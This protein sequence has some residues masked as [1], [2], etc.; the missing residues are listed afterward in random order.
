MNF[1]YSYFISH[2][3][4]T[5]QA[6]QMANIVEEW[7]DQAHSQCKDEEARCISVVKTLVVAKK[8][9]KELKTKPTEV[10]REGKSAE[11][12]LV[13]TQETSRGPMSTV[14]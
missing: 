6:I 13:G 7:V 5:F 14:A 10:D 1:S 4:A 9:I 3:I 8:R 12:A 11:A 2:I